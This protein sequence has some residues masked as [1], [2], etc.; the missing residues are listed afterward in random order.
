[1]GDEISQPPSIEY[2]NENEIDGQSFIDNINNSTENISKE[3]LIERLNKL[4][5]DFDEFVL[6]ILLIF[7]DLHNFFDFSASWE[8]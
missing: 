1:M 5:A 8:E 6:H 3:D 4:Q 7:F 2:Q